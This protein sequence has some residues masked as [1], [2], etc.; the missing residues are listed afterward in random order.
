MKTLLLIEDNFNL[1]KTNKKR[2]QHDCN[3]IVETVFSPDDAIILLKN[4]HNYKFIVCDYT[5][6]DS[7][8]LKVLKYLEKR[9]S[10]V[11]FVFYT[12]SMGLK[13]ETNYPRYFGIILKFNYKK[14]VQMIKSTLEN[15]HL[16]PSTLV[17]GN[18]DIQS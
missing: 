7:S 14:L 9:C 3:V 6:P 2:L 16:G 11:P 15:S 17:R 5:I 10:E 8:G 12:C 18:S 13:V 4:N 1:R